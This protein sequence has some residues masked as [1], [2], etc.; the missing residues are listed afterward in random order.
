MN[1]RQCVE[2]DSSDERPV[3]ALSVP[4][5]ILVFQQNGSAQSKIQGIQKYGQKLFTL[6]IISIDEALPPLIDDAREYLPSKIRASMVL[7]FLKHPDLSHDLAVLCRDQRIPLVASG[8]KLRTEGVLT[9]P[10]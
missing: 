8:K 10:T 4:Q 3:E 5:T 9:P 7:D 1:D 2:I 6:E